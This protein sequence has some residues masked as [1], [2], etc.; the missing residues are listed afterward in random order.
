MSGIKAVVHRME[1]VISV[2]KGEPRD[3]RES[4]LV[5][6]DGGTVLE[7]WRTIRSRPEWSNYGGVEAHSL[8]RPDYME[9]GDRNKSCTA[10]GEGCWNDGSGLAFDELGLNDL[11]DREQYALIG[12]LV[13]ERHGVDQ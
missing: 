8:T 7:A 4:V 2:E 9:E 5:V 13:T 6:L 1:T 11:F 12:E 3:M 10:T